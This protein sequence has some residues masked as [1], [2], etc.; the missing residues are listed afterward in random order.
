MLRLNITSSPRI[1]GRIIASSQS[2][3]QTYIFTPR[4]HLF[5]LVNT[6]STNQTVYT[7]TSL[8][9]FPGVQR[10]WDQGWLSSLTSIS[11]PHPL[12]ITQSTI[13]SSHGSHGHWH[14]HGR[15]GRHR[16]S[17]DLVRGN[18]GGGGGGGGGRG[19]ASGRGGR[20]LSL[21][22]AGV[23]LMAGTVAA[24]TYWEDLTAEEAYGGYRNQLREYIR[25]GWDG[26]DPLSEFF[27]QSPHPSIYS[28]SLDVH[29]G[30]T[31]QPG[32]NPP[33]R[34]PASEVRR[35]MRDP[36]ARAYFEDVL[37]RAGI[38]S[39]NVVG[40]LNDARGNESSHDVRHA[41]ALV[42]DP[43]ALTLTV[44]NAIGIG[45]Y[46][47]E[48]KRF[49][50]EETSPGRAPNLWQD[51]LPLACYLAG[52][53]ARHCSE[54]QK[55]FALTG[56]SYSGQFVAMMGDALAAEIP[57]V[58]ELGS[59]GIMAPAQFSDNM[60]MR[61]LQNAR[62]R[63]HVR[64]G[65]LDPLTLTSP[66]TSRVVNPAVDVQYELVSHPAGGFVKPLFIV[67][68]TNGSK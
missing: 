6:V 51:L 16:S 19:A 18:T 50:V 68:F 10:I 11:R 66:R 15:G 30:L 29:G 49:E 33:Y 7:T 1:F 40:S 53:V 31:I 63:T 2:Y 61:A 5:S 46:L 27:V 13:Q 65:M 32:N 58:A 21:T 9:S 25:K 67:L 3:N 54:H 64:H 56:H 8:F 55:P 45:A 48:L 35:L 60:L 41:A 22:A 23:I 17:Y 44:H 28:D 34:L 43:N 12:A 42:L 20:V 14:G 4:E 38:V 39:I 52:R 62:M 47:P 26:G 36:E 24:I 57:V 59:V 37:R